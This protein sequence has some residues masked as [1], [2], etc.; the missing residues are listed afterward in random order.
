[1]GIFGY[2]SMNSHA[3]DVCRRDC[4]WA[5]TQILTW[6]YVAAEVNIIKRAGQLTKGEKKSRRGIR[7][8]DG[9]E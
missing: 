7:M 4:Y 2:L 3:R 6:K 1:M 9:M 8:D 5:D